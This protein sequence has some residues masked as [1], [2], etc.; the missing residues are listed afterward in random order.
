MAKDFWQQVF[1]GHHVPAA[2]SS[3]PVPESPP[4]STPVLAT[5]WQRSS[6]RG[7]AVSVTSRSQSNRGPSVFGLE[8]TVA[9]TLKYSVRSGHGILPPPPHWSRSRVCAGKAEIAPANV[10]VDNGGEARDESRDHQ[11][12][13]TSERL[14]PSRAR[15]V[16]LVARLAIGGAT[17]HRPGDRV[18]E[19]RARNLRTAAWFEDR[20]RF[21]PA[22][23]HDNI[24]I[25]SDS[26]ESHGNRQRA[27]TR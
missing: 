26:G 18:I 5:L 10:G 25:A 9:S 27:A 8:S 22:M 16:R 20:R 1:V 6:H 11:A 7:P 12:T 21:V 14:N 13:R 3:P 4:E 24:L 2:R 17:R 23:Y 15:L 19:G